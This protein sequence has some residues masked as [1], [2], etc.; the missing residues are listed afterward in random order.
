MHEMAGR[1]LVPGHPP[2]ATADVATAVEAAKLLHVSR[3]TVK[4]W[5]RRTSFLP[6]RED[7]SGSPSDRKS[8]R[9]RWKSTR[10]E[11]RSSRSRLAV[12]LPRRH[13]EEQATFA[14]IVQ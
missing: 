2:L 8:K 10:A 4:H 9:S 7:D 12:D 14:L 13:F 11:P 3:S 1:P 5:A 6:R